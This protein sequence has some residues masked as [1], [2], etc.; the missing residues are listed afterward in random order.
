MES[1]TDQWDVAVIGGGQAGLATGY[2]LKKM[3]KRFI[4]L[5]EGGRIGDSWRKRWDSL[6]LFTPA[7]HDGL[8][9]L[10]F[11]GQGGHFPGKDEMADYLEQ[12]ANTFSLQVMLKAKVNRLI[13]VNS[14]FEIETSL[15]K[16]TA[17]NVVVTTGTNPH[18][19]IPLLSS[20]LSSNIF[21]IHSSEYVNAE[22]I[23]SGDVLVVGAATSGMEIALELAKTHK[24]FISGNPPFHIPDNLLKYGGELYWWIINNIIT[25]KT[26][27]GRK[28][29]DKISHGGSPL[30]RISADDLKA[31]GIKNL[32]RVAG[33]SEGYPLLEDKTTVKVRSV[34]WATGYKPDYSWIEMNIT[35]DLGWPVTKRGVSTLQKGLYFVGMPFQFGLTSGLV[36][37]IGRDAAYVSQYIQNA[38][39]SSKIDA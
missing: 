32:P 2:Y 36:G 35:N 18:P 31:A 8:P 33:T 37:G 15:S 24:T 27:I 34:I 28:V 22:S 5:D 20:D 26:A 17:K 6:M 7:K 12:Y 9:G 3:N 10:T 16:L 11:P 30:I 4:I 14:H 25:E 13:S 39:H 1:E 38:G 23:P 29:K 21:Q 19:R